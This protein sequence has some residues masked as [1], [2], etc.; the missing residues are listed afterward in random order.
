VVV[1]LPL[2]RFAAPGHAASHWTSVAP[3]G[4][5]AGLRSL[6]L[7][8]NRLSDVDATGK[9]QGLVDHTRFTTFFSSIACI[10]TAI[11]RA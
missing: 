11:N 4:V 7:D 10:T 3:L 5:L 6:R 9:I 2:Q 1:A 8:G